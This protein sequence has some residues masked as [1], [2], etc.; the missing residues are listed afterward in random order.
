MFLEGLHQFAHHVIQFEDEIA[1]RTRLGLPLEGIAGK[2]GQMHR[3]GRVQ[4]EERFVRRT[5][6]VVL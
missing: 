5:L 3:L 1:V 4:E 6:G 2:R